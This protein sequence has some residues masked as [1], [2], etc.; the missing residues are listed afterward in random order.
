MVYSA[1]MS[2]VSEAGSAPGQGDT[3]ATGADRREVADES[4]PALE[5][6]TG[7]LA[8]AGP[9]GRGDVAH[10]SRTTGP[11]NWPRL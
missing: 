10:G 9:V 1:N 5:A 7:R 3:P 11:E 8:S 6:V 4:H 2:A